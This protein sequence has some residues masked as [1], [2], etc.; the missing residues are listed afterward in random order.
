MPRAAVHVALVHHPVRDRAGRTV[1]TAITNLDIHDIARA[2]RT[3]GVGGYW[4]VTP[5]A[6]QRELALRI[7]AHWK[8]GASAERI[9]ERGQALS[10]V[11]VVASLAEARAGVVEAT[12]QAPFVVATAARTL[13][14]PTLGFDAGRRQIAAGEGPPWLLCF[15]TGFGLSDEVLD[16][17][18]ALLPPLSGPTEYNHLSVRAAAAIVLDRLLHVEEGGKGPP[19]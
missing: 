1:T 18:D 12:G 11:R 4:V 9:P 5:I 3:Y 10:L 13:G 7:V 19:G 17:A 6:A 8:T 16:G 15:G 14:R 2:S